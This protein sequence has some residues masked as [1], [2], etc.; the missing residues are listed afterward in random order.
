MLMNHK[1]SPETV[2][3]IETQREPGQSVARSPEEVMMTL[4]AIAN[5]QARGKTE[6]PAVGQRTP[7]GGVLLA[8][9]RRAVFVDIGDIFKRD[10]CGGDQA[11]PFHDIVAQGNLP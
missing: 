5:A 9:R 2:L 8:A 1:R 7:V 3:E 4:A 6:F 10:G 11:G